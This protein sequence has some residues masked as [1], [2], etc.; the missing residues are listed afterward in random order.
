MQDYWKMYL[1]PGS[2]LGVLG[3]LGP[4]GPLSSWGPIGSNHW[5]PSNMFNDPKCDWCSSMYADIFPCLSMTNASL[6]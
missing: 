3:P 5:N 6:G 1:E 4:S 2:A